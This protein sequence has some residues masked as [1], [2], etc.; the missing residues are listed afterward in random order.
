VQS[1]H[2]L[3]IAQMSAQKYQQCLNQADLGSIVSDIKLSNNFYFA[4][5]YHQQ[6]LSKNPNGYCGLK[7]T[8][9]KCC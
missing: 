1:E 3:Q 5:D 6:Y 4:E 7:G 9:V 2:D 8:G